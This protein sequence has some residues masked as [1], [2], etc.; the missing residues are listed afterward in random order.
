MGRKRVTYNVNYM[1]FLSDDFLQ[2]NLK[3]PLP[4]NTYNQAFVKTKSDDQV[5]SDSDHSS[6]EFSDLVVSKRKPKFFKFLKIFICTWLQ[7]FNYN[8]AI[9]MLCFITVIF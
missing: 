1:L 4:R 2:G 9:H 5:T 3:P 7:I 8:T 6:I